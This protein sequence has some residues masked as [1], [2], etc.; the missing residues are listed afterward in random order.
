MLD[1]TII[2][3]GPAGLN[4]ALVLGRAKRKVVLFDNNQARN[5]VTQESHGFI[6]RD[7]VSPTEFRELAYQDIRK[8]PS[9]KVERVKI[10]E[11]KKESSYLFT[12]ATEEGKMFTSKKVMLS[13]GLKESLPSIKGINEYYGKSLFSCPYC[14]GWELRDLPLVLIGENSNTTHLAKMIYQWSHNLVVCTNGKSVLEE[15]DELLLK[16]KGM[17]IKKERIETLSGSNGK[18]EKV[19]FEDGTTMNR[20]GGFVTTD[21]QQPNNLAISLGCELNHT[22]GIIVDDFGRTNI[23]GV[24]AAGETTFFGPSQLIIAAGQGVRA[25]A[26]INHDLIMKEFTSGEF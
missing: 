26:G 10:V 6:T 19:I 8:Y 13:T 12:V 2:G 9:V 24:Y 23:E 18:L 21:L 17:I 5:K 25:A 1:C 7:G 14:D 22:N 4:A 15:E 20:V 11:I 16:R 3:G